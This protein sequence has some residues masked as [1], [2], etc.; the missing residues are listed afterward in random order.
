LDRFG[1][2][3]VLRPD[4]RQVHHG[5]AESG[6]PY[7][8]REDRPDSAPVDWQQLWAFGRIEL[9]FD[10]RSFGRLT[11]LELSA[12][13]H[14]WNLKQDREDFRFASIQ[15]LT[16]EINRDREKRPWPFTPFDF[17]TP[18]SK[19]KEPEPEKKTELWQTNLAVVEMLNV[20]FGGRDLRAERRAGL[21]DSAGRPILPAALAD[22]NDGGLS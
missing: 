19:P 1:Q 2:Y 9:G 15:A 5:A 17:F 21:V 12:H 13:L 18:R 6:K 4:A 11:P 7:P 14:V 20:A 16:A 10:S 8:G 22:S 3:G